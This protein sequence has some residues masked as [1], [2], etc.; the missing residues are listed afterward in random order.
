MISSPMLYRL[1]VTTENDESDVA[2]I[3]PLS[4]PHVVGS[5][6]KIETHK[7]PETVMLM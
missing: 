7:Q 2:V 5:T 3:E 4:N 1:Y 6:P